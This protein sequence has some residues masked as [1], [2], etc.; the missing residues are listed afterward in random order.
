[1]AEPL[2]NLTRTHTCGAL[3]ADDVGA[4][5]VLLGWAHRIRDLGGVTFIDIRDRAGISQVVVRENEALMGV[6][7]RLRSEFVIG[8]SGVVQRRSEDTINPKLATGEV[9]V[10]S[11]DIRIL[12]E[13]KTPPFQIAEDS[14]VSEDVRLKYRY[15]DLRR[16]RLQYNMSLRHRVTMAVRKYFDANGFLE[17]ETPV[18]TKSTPEGARDFLVP[19]RIHPGEF[20]ALPQSPQIFKQ[21]LMISGMD[22]YF[23]IVK[24]FRDE[25]QRADRQLEFTQIDVEM[26]F[27]RPELVYGL[28][29]PLMQTILKEIGRDVALPIRRMRYAD[30]I[31]KYGSDKPDLRFGLEI[32]DLSEVFRDSEFRVFK[33]IVAD[34]GVVRGFAVT[35][36]NRYTRSQIDVL[37]DQAKQMG[38]SGLIWVRPGEPPTSSVKA[39]TEATLR[40]ALERAGASKDDLLLMAAG[41]ADNTSKLLGQLRLAIAKKENLAGPDSFE[42]LWVTEFPLLEYHEEDGRWYSM[43]HPFTSPLDEDIDKVDNDPGAARAKAYDLVLN[44]S[45]IGGGSI[46]IHDAALQSRMFQRLGISDEEAKLRFGFFLEALAYGTPPHGGIALGVDRIVAILCGESSIREVIA[47]PKTANA[48]DLMSDAPS[49][50]DAKQLKELH[51][52]VQP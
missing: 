1:M 33:Q 8:V 29:E 46:R 51:L 15:L 35:A 42:F 7:K 25:D 3:R 2:G 20:Y 45:E 5:V 23:Q 6:A 48:V 4:E 36:G 11:R 30:A 47:F 14:P 37:V 32:R 13:A 19:S 28:I 52:K 43:H 31:A 12:N 17:I 50:V 10:L 16:P 24:C 40:A 9:E 21:I 44:G 27:A 18:L 39:L 41:P 34:G 22:R 26:S 38:F 49:P